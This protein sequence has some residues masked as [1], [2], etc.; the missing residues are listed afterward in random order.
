MKFKNRKDVRYFVMDMY[1]VYKDIAKRLLPNATIVIDKF[2][3]VKQ[4]TFQVDLQHLKHLMN[5]LISELP[6]SINVL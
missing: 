4:V 1:K 2:H 3:V 6:Q 5:F